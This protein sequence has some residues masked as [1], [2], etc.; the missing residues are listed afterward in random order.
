MRYNPEI[1]QRRSI[2]LKEYD[3][4]Q[5]GAYFITICTWN[6]ERLFGNILNRN[7]ELS[8]NGD[9]TFQ[10]WMDIPNHFNNVG[11]D[12]F[13]VMPNHVHGIIMCRGEVTSPFLKMDNSIKM[14]GTT[15]MDGETQ[16]GGTTQGGETPP[17]RKRTLGQIVAYYKY[18]TTKHLNQIRDTP[19]IPVWQRNYYDHIIRN[20]YD[21][22]RI[23]EY[24]I[25]NPLQWDEDEYNPENL[26]E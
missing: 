24:I 23:R 2:R 25:N 1:H 14:G 26:K 5:A 8:S 4:S 10:Y 22:H 16:M 17:L 18:Q 19:G 9:I 6:K 11:L 13:I 20:E 7:V 3:Y 21:L 12:E 15:Q